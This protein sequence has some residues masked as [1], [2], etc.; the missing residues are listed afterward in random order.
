MCCSGRY[1]SRA[2][3]SVHRSAEGLREGL[4]EQH[5]EGR[6]GTRVLQIDPFIAS[7]ARNS[8]RFL[9]LS[10]RFLSV[11]LQFLRTQFIVGI[12]IVDS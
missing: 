8:L 12:V 2:R 6:D 7:S 11:D 10:R 1:A 5:Q 4:Q 9:T 3:E